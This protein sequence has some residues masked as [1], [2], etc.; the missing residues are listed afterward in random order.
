MHELPWIT[1]LGS[2]VKR[3][4]NHFREWWSHEWKSLANRFTS[5]RKKSL[6][7]ITN[8]SF[9]FLCAIRYV[10]NTQFRYKQLSISDFAIVAKGGP[11]WLSIVTSPQ[12]IC[13]VTWTWSTGIVTS[14]SSIVLARANWRKGDL[15][16]WITNVNID[17]SPP[18]IHGL[19]YRRVSYDRSCPVAD[20]SLC[21][22]SP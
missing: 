19:A 14:Y 5:D 2:R 22:T 21:A 7:T 4:A 18:G 20:H 15:H 8:V 1:I 13:D 3:F 11:F 6:F 16:W 9:Y 17:F 10:L 12:L